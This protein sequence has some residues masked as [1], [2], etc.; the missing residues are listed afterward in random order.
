MLSTPDCTSAQPDATV[1][2]TSSSCMCLIQEDGACLASAT[3]KISKSDTVTAD[4]YI[5]DGCSGDAIGGDT[6]VACGTCTAESILTG[7]VA[8]QIV[9]PF[10]A[11]GVCSQIGIPGGV[12]C[13]ASCGVALM[14][15]VVAG[16]CCCR[17][18]KQDHVASVAH[19]Q[20]P[21]YYHAPNGSE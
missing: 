13:Y 18:R 9:C 16:C 14:I 7:G 5:G 1:A 21:R 8:F 15:L 12:D 2:F 11:F 3:L 17:R 19:I 10:N 6:E 20:A 4:V